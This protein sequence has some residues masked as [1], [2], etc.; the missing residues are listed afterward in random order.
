MTYSI[1]EVAKKT[2]MSVHTLR[3]YDKEG[4]LPFLERVNGRRVFREEDLDRLKIINCLKNTGMPLKDIGR[5]MELCQRGDETLLQRQEMIRRQKE[6]IEEQLRQLQENLK[7]IDYKVWYYETAV[8]AGTEQI[9]R[10][11][12]KPGE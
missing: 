3:F 9:H 12:A 2:G 7:F 1:S 6:S 10:G 5:Y 8:A 4:L 11:P